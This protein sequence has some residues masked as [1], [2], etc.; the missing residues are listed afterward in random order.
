MHI[1]NESRPWLAN[2]EQQK[3]FSRYP[4]FFRA[5]SYPDAY[6]SNLAFFGIQCG[7]GW[8]P[9]IEAA[10]QEIEAELRTM[11][12]E[13]AHSVERMASIDHGLLME[14]SSVYPVIPLCSDIRETAGRLKISLLEGHLCD[15]E[16][17]LRIRQSGE[18]AI[19]LAGSVCERCGRPGNLREIYWHHVYCDECTA[20]VHLEGHTQSEGR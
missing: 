9:V 11:W 17:W 10:A 5:V 2:E 14:M 16:V 7:V 8:Y 1:V 18:K 13:Q 4:L 15:D 19:H 12:C 6:P 3:L 20:P